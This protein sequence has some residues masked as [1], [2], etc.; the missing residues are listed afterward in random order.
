[1]LQ[2]S[3]TAYDMEE[4]S[5]PVGYFVLLEIPRALPRFLHQFLFSF[6]Y[7]MSVGKS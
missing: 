2:E 3:Q 5:V 1:M 4:E 6:V 7:P